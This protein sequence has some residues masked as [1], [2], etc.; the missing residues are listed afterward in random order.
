MFII[1]LTTGARHG[2]TIFCDWM[3]KRILQWQIPIKNAPWGVFLIQGHTYD[4]AI[5]TNLVSTDKAADVTTNA[6]HP[7]FI[8]CLVCA[9]QTGCLNIANGL[10]D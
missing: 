9:V 6:V 8:G 1:T 7:F 5:G 10:V 4:V 3:I 2:M